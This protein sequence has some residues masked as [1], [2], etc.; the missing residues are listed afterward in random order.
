MSPGDPCMNLML[1]EIDVSESHRPYDAE[2]VTRLA[3]S[4]R[5]IGLQ[6]PITAVRG[7]GKRFNLVAGRHRLEAF[8]LL[9]RDRIPANVVKMDD[10]AARMWEIA[11]N[12]HRAE[13][14]VAQRADQ[15][16]EYARLAKAKRE[17]ER[18]VSAD[19]VEEV[20]A[21]RSLPAP[22]GGSFE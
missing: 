1:D 22:S 17:A 13:L 4:I 18:E 3:K 11:E 7:D 16:S 15:I 10:R 12:L 9:G 21:G 14:T 2:A 8:R 19:I 6:Y 20:R 5:D